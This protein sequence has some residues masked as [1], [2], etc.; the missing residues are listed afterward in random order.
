MQNTNHSIT[1]V[2][3]LVDRRDND[4]STRDLTTSD[5]A[6][7]RNQVL[8]WQRSPLGTGIHHV[9][10]KNPY[11]H[12]SIQRSQ[13]LCRQCGCSLRGNH[14]T[15]SCGKTAKRVQWRRAAVFLQRSGLLEIARGL[16]SLAR[17]SR[18]LQRE[19]DK[20][21]EDAIRM[22]HPTKSRKKNRSSGL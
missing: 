12:Q 4:S 20:L 11:K 6:A 13:N 14:K 5:S 15:R 10:Q 2:R 1:D 19:I 21:E 9:Y 3:L 8:N 17:E 16:E 7:M 18:E 22:K